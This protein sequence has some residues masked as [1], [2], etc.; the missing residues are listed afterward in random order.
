MSKLL[1]LL[2]LSLLMALGTIQAM[3]LE[4][5]VAADFIAKELGSPCVKERINYAISK[6]QRD[7]IYNNV[8]SRNKYLNE[9]FEQELSKV[10]GLPSENIAAKVF[11]AQELGSSCDQEK[12]NAATSKWEYDILPHNDPSRKPLLIQAL[13]QEL[14]KACL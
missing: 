8:P 12:I 4:Q 7:I 9:A 13:K 2:G 6:W 5:K 3:T 14:N 11:I 10:C 1:K